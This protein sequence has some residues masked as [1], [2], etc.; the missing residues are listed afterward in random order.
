MYAYEENSIDDSGTAISPNFATGGI[1]LNGWNYF[2]VRR[3]QAMTTSASGKSLNIARVGRRLGPSFSWSTT[4]SVDN[5]GTAFAIFQ[6]T[7]THTEP[8]PSQG[9]ERDWE[10]Y[11]DVSG[12][13]PPNFQFIRFECTVEEGGSQT[14][15]R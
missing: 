7:P 15:V 4:M 1:T 9:P 6:D 12:S 14:G 10:W 8:S 2:Y 5:G 3:C 11:L 13:L